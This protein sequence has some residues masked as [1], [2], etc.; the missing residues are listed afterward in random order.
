MLREVL[1]T[2]QPGDGE[3]FIDAT[4]GAGGYSQGVLEAAD[5]RLIALDRDP[6]AIAAGQAM[7]AIF[8]PRLQLVMAPFSSLFEGGDSADGNSMAW[9]EGAANLRDVDGVVFDLGV[10]S[11]QLDREER[12]FSFLRDGP[13]DMR[14]FVSEGMPASEAG[15]SAADV[16]NTFDEAE[17]ADILFQLGEEKRSRAIAKAIVARRTERPFTRTLDLAGVIEAVFGGRRGEVRHPA[18]RSFQA[19]RMFVN[20]EIGELLLG[21][22]GAERALNAGGRLVVVTFH[23]LEDRIVK[24]FIAARSGRGQGVSRHLPD[25]GEAVRPASFQIV[26]PASLTSSQDEIDVNPRSRSARLRWAVR[27]D[28]PAWPFDID[29]LGVPRLARTGLEDLSSRG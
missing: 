24:R 10:S 12:G 18:T 9:G 14:M 15:P 2:L 19:L 13:L 27:T 6:S 17:I 11:M 26:N 29:D 3:T 20:D 16:V 7:V 23:S 5:C 28:A 22:A 25:S 21:L 1:R 8:G 4:F